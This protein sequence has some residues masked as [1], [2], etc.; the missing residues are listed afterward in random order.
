MANHTNT[1]QRC[2]LSRDAADVEA[3]FARNQIHEIH[4]AERLFASRQNPVDS[5]ACA[6]VCIG[7]IAK[8][9]QRPSEAVLARAHAMLA[10]DGVGWVKDGERL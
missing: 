4:R 10:V 9:D 5:V 6:C 1:R 8:K 7:I 2:K 3:L